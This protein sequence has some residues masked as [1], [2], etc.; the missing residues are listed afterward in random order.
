MLKKRQT[1][2][3]LTCLAVAL[4]VLTAGSQTPQ[5]TLRSLDGGSVNL[6]SL[7]GKVA[8]ISFGNKENP[9]AGKELPALQKLADRYSSRGVQF[10]WVSIN[11][12]KPGSRNYA[13]DDDLRAFAQKHNLRLT[14]LRD[15]D[16]E[17]YRAFGLDAL[18]TVVVLDKQGRVA[19]KHVGFGADPGDTYSEI[20]RD[21]EQLLK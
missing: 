14:V 2:T 5:A 6:N 8:V 4:I 15:P 10:Y 19:R 11:N 13:S 12:A 9:L 16:Q 20:I 21:I 18:P 1:V 3:V 7:R 17:A